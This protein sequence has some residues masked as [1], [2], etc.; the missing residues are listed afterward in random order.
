[1]T[2]ESQVRTCYANLKN[3][4]ATLAILSNQT[5]ELSSRNVYKETETI[6]KEI[7]EDME[8]QLILLQKEEPQYNQ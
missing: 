1:M 3:I 8:K 5:N 6:I 2:V 7:K 4:E